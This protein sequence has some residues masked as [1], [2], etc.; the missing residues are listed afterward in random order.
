MDRT[1]F[2]V[3]ITAFIVWRIY[4]RLR[5]N[6]GRQ[7]LR[8][9]RILIRL[10]ILCLAVLGIAVILYPFPHALAGFAAGILLGATLGFFGLRLTKFETTSE[11]HF[12]IPDTR[13]GVGI[14]L[15]LTG[16]IIY[17]LVVPPDF[18]LV[19]GHPSPRWSPLTFFLAGI[20]IGYFIVYSTGLY[21]HSRDKNKQQN[22]VSAGNSL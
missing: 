13:M 17:R 9:R 15:L 14:T 19:P 18:T 8:P 20:T 10:V 5:R 12:Y 4:R 21:L 3:A 2:Y 6:I 22:A 7:P 1:V 11:G 16:R